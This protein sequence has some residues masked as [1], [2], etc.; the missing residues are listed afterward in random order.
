MG[1]GRLDSVLGSYS[2]LGMDF[3]PI[4]RS[5]LTPLLSAGIGTGSPCLKG[6]AAVRNELEKKAVGGT[7]LLRVY[8]PVTQITCQKSHDTVPL[9]KANRN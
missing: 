5:K 7:L 8:R 9:K 1:H 2:I 6:V 3:S 4:T